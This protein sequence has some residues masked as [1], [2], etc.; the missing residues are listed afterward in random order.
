[1]VKPAFLSFCSASS[2]ER[3]IMPSIITLS[4]LYVILKLY[5]FALTKLCSCIR[6]LFITEPGSASVLYTDSVSNLKLLLYSA[7]TLYRR[8]NFYLRNSEPQPF[9]T[10][11]PRSMPVT[12]AAI[13]TRPAIMPISIGTVLLA[14]FSSSFLSS[15]PFTAGA[16]GLVLREQAA[17]R[18]CRLPLLN[19][20]ILGSLSTK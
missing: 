5:G 18:L 2:D 16:A 3:P 10:L 15:S 19:Q 9:L 14:G 6:S 12:I 1:M 4:S 7:L 17:L 8:Y 11:R 20:Q 13:T